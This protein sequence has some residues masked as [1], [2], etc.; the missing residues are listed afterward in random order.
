[1]TELLSLSGGSVV[2]RTTL[3]MQEMQETRVQSLFGKI[4]WSKKRQ[5]T[6]ILL[7]GKFHEQRSLVGFSPW[8]CTKLD[9][10]ERLSTRGSG[11]LGTSRDS[12]RVS[13]LHGEE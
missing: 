7:P 3:P 12:V 8:G 10:T 6:P 1:M 2:E 5:I 4:P 11:Q 13:S 9:M